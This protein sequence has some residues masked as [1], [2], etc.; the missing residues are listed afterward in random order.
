MC[1]I[2]FGINEHPDYPLVI[3]ANR[4]EDLKRPTAPASLWGDGSGVL[5]GRDLLGNGTWLGVSEG[6][7]I[8]CVTN[9]REPGVHRLGAKSRGQLVAGLL[10]GNGDVTTEMG[11]V[12]GS[13]Y[14]GFNLLVFTQG[15]AYYRSNRGNESVAILNHGF[16]GL[17]NARLDTPWP[18][19]EQG[20]DSL[21]EAVS[22]LSVGEPEIDPFFELLASRQ[23]A[24]DASLPDTGVGLELERVL[25][26]AFVFAKGYGTR[27]STVILMGHERGL[28]VERT[29]PPG[30]GPPEDRAFSFS[31]PKSAR[32]PKGVPTA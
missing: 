25:S 10:R 7:R 32:Q 15:N 16:H 4:D 30:S 22:S 29:Y 23:M 19:V 27:S 14:N 2:L 5:G 24:P 28:F 6:R 18:K 26:S 12:A 21:R 8:V 31:Y 3:A 20:V 9:V 11:Q 1:L 17:S 13:D